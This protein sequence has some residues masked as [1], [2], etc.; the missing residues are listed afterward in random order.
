[1]DTY[2]MA[3]FGP[4]NALAGHG[5]PYRFRRKFGCPN[6]ACA[7]ARHGAGAVGRRRIGR[8]TIS[9]RIDPMAAYAVIGHAVERVELGLELIPLADLPSGLL[10]FGLPR[11]VRRQSPTPGKPLRTP[12]HRATPVLASVGDPYRVGRH[13]PTRARGRGG[14]WRLALSGPPASRPFVVTCPDCRGRCQI[15]GA[16]PADELVRRSRAVRATFPAV[17]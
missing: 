2:P 4:F 11:S 17:L 16:L 14:Y 9:E 6:P 7:A 5:G 8:Q 15:D 3:V 13:D 12:L 1:M 10:S